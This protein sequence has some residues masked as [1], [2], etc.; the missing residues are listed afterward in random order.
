[1]PSIVLVRHGQASF[2]ADNYDHLSELGRR[3]AVATGVFLARAGIRPDRVYSGHLSRQIDTASLAL[4]S[5][6]C[7]PEMERLE[8][9]NEYDSDGVFAA[10]LPTV[11]EDHPDIRDQIT[12]EDYS[13]LKDRRLF[14]RLFFPVMT[15]WI[16]G[17]G[18]VSPRGNVAHEPWIDFY[19]R[20][21]SGLDQVAQSLTDQECAVIFTSGG[22]IAASVVHALGLDHTRSPEFNWRTANASVT[23]LIHTDARLELEGYN[24][25]AHL[26]SKDDGLR[27]TYL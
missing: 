8:A 15:R 2:G 11:L 14:R 26:Q 4:K 23:R 9:F 13:A 5:M 7:L 20:V 1:M 18:E 3:Q 12:P 6:G 24:N 22:V 27:V 21:V 16:E 17:Q 25:Y 19:A 10:F